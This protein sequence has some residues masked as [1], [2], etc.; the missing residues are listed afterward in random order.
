[1]IYDCFP[2]FDELDVLEIRL[3]ELADVVDR[4]VIVGG[5]QNFP[6]EGQ[7]ALLC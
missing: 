7:A 2:F 5:N 6:E 3:K 4:F 1:M